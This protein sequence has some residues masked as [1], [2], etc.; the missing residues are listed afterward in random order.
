MLGKLKEIGVEDTGKGGVEGGWHPRG[1]GESI[2][3]GLGSFNTMKKEL[4]V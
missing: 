3:G 1:I 4:E 2:G